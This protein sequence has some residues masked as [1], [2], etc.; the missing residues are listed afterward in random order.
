MACER[1]YEDNNDGRKDENRQQEKTG[2]C[3][4]TAKYCSVHPYSRRIVVATINKIDDL[5]LF[6][7]PLPLLPLLLLS[8]PRRLLISDLSSLSEP[9]RGSR[10]ILDLVFVTVD[11]EHFTLLARCAS[12]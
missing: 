3:D 7:L 9:P 4:G 6:A 5:P 12:Q 2:K 8:L 1:Q 10:L 11:D